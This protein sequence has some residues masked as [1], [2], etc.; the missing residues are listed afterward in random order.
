MKE[1][2]THTDFYKQILE[3]LH[4][5]QNVAVFLSEEIPQDF[6]YAEAEVFGKR[7]T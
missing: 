2:A 3:N 6:Y 4:F 7:L 1:W 5:D